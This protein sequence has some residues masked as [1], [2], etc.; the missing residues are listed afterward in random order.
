VEVATWAIFDRL[1]G[2]RDHATDKPSE[3]VNMKGVDIDAS[4]EYII[5]ETTLYT[6]CIT[7]ALVT[8]AMTGPPDV[9]QQLLMRSASPESR[10]TKEETYR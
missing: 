8:G 2:S 3:L 6:C 9:V 7:H 10:T 5:C 4:I 1:S